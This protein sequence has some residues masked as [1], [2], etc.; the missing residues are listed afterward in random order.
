MAAAWAAPEASTATIRR[1]TFTS[2]T[3]QISTEDEGDGSAKLQVRKSMVVLCFAVKMCMCGPD[4][5]YEFVFA[6]DKTRMKG[7]SSQPT[8]YVWKAMFKMIFF[9]RIQR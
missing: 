3:T 7:V 8:H 2:S 9:N 6:Y 5:M 1:L 4:L